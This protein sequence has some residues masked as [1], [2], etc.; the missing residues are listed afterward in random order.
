[1]LNG[2]LA[3]VVA[4]LSFGML[5]RLSDEQSNSLSGDPLTAFPSLIVGREH[6]TVVNIC[7]DN[8]NFSISGLSSVI[9]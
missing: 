3:G 8:E 1:M 7:R 5:T 2:H 4:E 9:V 6:G